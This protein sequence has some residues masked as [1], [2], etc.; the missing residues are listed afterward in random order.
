MKIRTEAEIVE[1]T[2]RPGV[3]VGLAWTPTGGDV[4]FVEANAMKGKAAS[5]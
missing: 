3:M 4:L 5:P 1:R 2:K